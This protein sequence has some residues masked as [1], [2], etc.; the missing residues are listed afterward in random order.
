MN[1]GWTCNTAHLYRKGQSRLHSM[2]R[3]LCPVLHCGVL[4]GQHIQEGHVQAGQQEEGAVRSL[5][6]NTMFYEATLDYG[7]GAIPHHLSDMFYLPL[8]LLCL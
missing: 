1:C 8:S 2:R 4:R 3:L 6:T 7:Q 5:T